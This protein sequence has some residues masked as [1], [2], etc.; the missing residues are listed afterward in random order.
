MRISFTDTAY[1]AQLLPAQSLKSYSTQTKLQKKYLLQALR[2][3]Q[4]QTEVEQNMV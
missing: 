2:S 1:C 4:I 3:A